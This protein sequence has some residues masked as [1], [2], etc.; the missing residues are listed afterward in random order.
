MTRIVVF[1][2]LDGTLLDEATYS[3][4]AAGDALNLLKERGM[5]LIICSSKT[6]A[7]IEHYR[8]KL[9]N[10]DPFICENGGGIFVPREYDILKDTIRAVSADDS[11]ESYFT[12]RLGASYKDLRRA[13]ETLRTQGFG[14]KG[15]GDMTIDEVSQ[16]TGLPP[17]EAIMAKAREF[18][19]PFLFDGGPHEFQAFLEAVSSL[20]FHATRGRFHHLLGDSDKGK[21]VSIVNALYGESL[22]EILS[23]GLGDSPNDNPMLER[24]DLPVIVQKR[25]GRYDPEINIPDRVRAPGVGPD[26]WSRFVKSLVSHYSPTTTRNELIVNF[27]SGGVFT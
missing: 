6:R 21:A 9:G 4:E 12:I 26:G 13:I 18:D 3:F 22:G 20:G 10:R 16:V 15:F 23:V 25:D 7:E 8:L 1:T 5:P 17:D 24:V 19:E 14:V 2:D 27:L 11:S